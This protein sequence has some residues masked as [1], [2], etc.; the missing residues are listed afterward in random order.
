M[1]EIWQKFIIEC[2]DIFDSFINSL[3]FFVKE[4]FQMIKNG[5]ILFVQTIFKWLWELLRGVSNLLITFL[6]TIYELLKN[7]IKSTF[8][9]LYEK[10]INWIEKW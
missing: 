10:I 4:T 6:T 5:C 9:F 2:K 8:S 7:T 1:K 3:K